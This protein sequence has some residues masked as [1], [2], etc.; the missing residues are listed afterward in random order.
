MVQAFGNSTT[1]LVL[2]VDA[3]SESHQTLRVGRVR[4][5][6]KQHP[7]VGDDE[8][9]AGP[10]LKV[11]L[12]DLSIPDVVLGGSKTKKFVELQASTDK[13]QNSSG[14]NRIFV[15][16]NQMPGFGNFLHRITC[17]RNKK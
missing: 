3:S 4:I 1:L 5:T 10:V 2:L 6:P 17:R 13:M 9:D 11:F 12:P 8:D 16:G 14:L 15:R 7:V